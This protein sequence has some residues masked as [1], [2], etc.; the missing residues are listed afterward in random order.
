[1]KKYFLLI[2]AVLFPVIVITAYYT[3]FAQ[4]VDGNWTVTAPCNIKTLTGLECPGCGGQRALHFLL[5]GHILIAMRYNLFFV[6]A[7]PFLAVFYIRFVQVYILKQ[8]RFLKSFV[9]STYFA[10]GLLIAVLL[11]FILR[12]I[13]IEPFIYLAPPV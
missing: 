3:L 2:V 1:M 10:Y 11:F 12:N 6:L 4:T 7:M 9:F 8:D 13:P 5:H